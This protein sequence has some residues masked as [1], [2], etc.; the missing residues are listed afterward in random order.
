MYFCIHHPTLWRLIFW[1]HHFYGLP[2]LFFP[3][4]L[5]FIMLRFPSYFH[6]VYIL[7]TIISFWGFGSWCCFR[8]QIKLWKL[9]GP[10]GGDKLYFRTRLAK[11]NGPNRVG[12]IILPDE[13]NR[14]T[15]R[16]PLLLDQN[17]KYVKCAIYVS[18]LQ[19]PFLTYLM[20]QFF[21]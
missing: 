5:C 4:V 20:L 2:T 11:A 9:L 17:R 6:I 8:H 16:L 13:G 14:A 1:F 12:C 3:L 19:H 21:K 7:T 10:L 15:S 18:V